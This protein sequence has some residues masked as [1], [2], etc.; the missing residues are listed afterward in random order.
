MTLVYGCDDAAVVDYLSHGSSTSAQELLATYEIPAGRVYKFTSYKD[1]KGYLTER[2]DAFLTGKTSTQY[3]AISDVPADNIPIIDR[4]RS[5]SDLPGMRILY[6]HD[7]EMLIIR[8]VPGLEHEMASTLFSDMVRDT[9]ASTGTPRGLLLDI[10]KHN[11]R[12]AG[13]GRQ[14]ERGR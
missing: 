13:P 11:I 8:L 3:V 14:A 7:A 10:G 6:D 4:G 12:S 9:V 5:C 1:L 2:A